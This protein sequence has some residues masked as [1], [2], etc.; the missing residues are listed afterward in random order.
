MEIANLFAFVQ[1][2]CKKYGI[3]E[4]H[5]LKHSM[6][7]VCWAEKLALAYNDIPPYEYD[8]IIYSAALHD[9]CDSKYRN[10]SEA[11]D[12]IYSW[13]LEQQ[14]TKET[15]NAVIDIITTISYSKL[16]MS[17]IDGKPKIYPDHGRWQRAYHIVRHADLLEAYR[18]VRCYLYSK[19]RKPAWSEDELWAE[20]RKIFDERIFKYVSD[21][22]IFLEQALKFV[23]DLER[24]ALRCFRERD[25][26][27][28]V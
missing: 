12:E 2:N 19:H 18:V 21:G 23:P 16:K 17:Q 11:S 22:W 6:G 25:C 8:I 3:D 4:S 10:L 15:A 27:Y 5:G 9:M 7:T 20:T 26:T 1:E 13:L 24:E 28:L 14:C